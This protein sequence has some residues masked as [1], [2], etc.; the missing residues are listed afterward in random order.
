MTE[1]LLTV[2]MAADAIVYDRWLASI[3]RNLATRKEQRSTLSN[4]AHKG[5]NTRRRN[6]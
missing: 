3:D 1:L 5:W 2:P 4:R 6:G